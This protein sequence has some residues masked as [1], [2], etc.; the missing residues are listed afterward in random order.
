[1]TVLR[2]TYLRTYLSMS[3]L[4]P[5]DFFD[6]TPDILF[7]PVLSFKILSRGRQ[8]GTGTG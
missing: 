4:S 5:D 3:E 1:M 7:D 6:S 8:V 2:G